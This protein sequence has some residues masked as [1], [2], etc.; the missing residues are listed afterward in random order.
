MEEIPY[1]WQLAIREQIQPWTQRPKT[2]RHTT[3][4]PRPNQAATASKPAPT[5]APSPGQRE[6]PTHRRAETPA[7]GRECDKALIG[8]TFDG[9]PKMIQE[10]E[11]PK[12]QPDA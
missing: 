2:Q 9:G 3:P 6:P 12:T 8:L 1:S 4:Q 7:T 11:Q 5:R 10:S